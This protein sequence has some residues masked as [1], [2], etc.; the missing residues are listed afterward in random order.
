[1][2]IHPKICGSD[3]SSIEFLRPMIVEKYPKTRVPTIPPI[4][5]SDPINDASSFVIIPL[6]KGDFEDFKSGIAALV[7]PVANP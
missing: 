1:M 5:R 2:R 3:I 4:V 6:F 7:Q